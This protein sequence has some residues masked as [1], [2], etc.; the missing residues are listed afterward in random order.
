MSM[1]VHT[2]LCVCAYMYINVYISIDRKIDFRS[3]FLDD[4]DCNPNMKAFRS[5]IICNLFSNE[6]AQ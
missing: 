2:L 3:S 5:K 6:S 1:C 4:F